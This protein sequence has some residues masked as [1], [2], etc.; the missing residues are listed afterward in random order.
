MRRREK[1]KREWKEGGG[2]DKWRRR[3]ERKGKKREG[4]RRRGKG[5]G[6]IRK[7]SEKKREKIYP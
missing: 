6:E 4:K 5:K 7:E 1:G 2:R 3:V